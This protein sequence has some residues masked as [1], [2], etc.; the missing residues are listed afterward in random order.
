MFSLADELKYIYKILICT[1]T[2]IYIPTKDEFD[3][4]YIGHVPINTNKNGRYVVGS[5]I[6]KKKLLPISENDIL[7]Y[8]SIFDIILI[9]ADGSKMKAIKGWKEYEPVIPSFTTKTI[10]VVDIY[11]IGKIINEENVHNVEEFMEITKSS[12]CEIININHII[13]L[14]NS[15][16]GLFKNS[17]GDKIIYIPRNNEMLIEEIEKSLN[18]SIK[19]VR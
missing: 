19:V 1:T 8:R 18:K 5:S 10:G 11:N 3:F 13:S 2:K 14:I 17:K 9:E 4:F 6:Y 15:E 16:K 7:K 12:K